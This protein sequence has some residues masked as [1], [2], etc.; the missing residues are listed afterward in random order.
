M[1]KRKPKKSSLLAYLAI[2]IGTIFIIAI[3]MMIGYTYGKNESKSVIES[4]QLNTKELVEKLRSIVSSADYSLYEI[5]GAKHEYDTTQTPPKPHL[6]EEPQEIKDAK[7]VIIID[8]VATAKDIEMIKSTKLPLVMSFLPPNVIHPDSALLASNID[9]YMVHLPLEAQNYDSPE[10]ITLLAGASYDEIDAQI[11]SVKSL[12][13]KVKYIN[14]H[15]GSKFTDDRESMS[16]LLQVL[17]AHNIKFVDSRTIGSSKVAEASKELGVRYLG[18]DIFLDHE[19]GVEYAKSQIIEAIKV[20]K[21][22]G[23]A[24]AIG[25][26]KR[27]TIRAL[28]ES[29]EL[30]ESSVKIVGIEQI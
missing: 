6:R 29:K 20:A 21:K 26:P 15:T 24:I 10:P 1:A 23:Y 11:A 3:S 17:N 25:H 13:P 2:F 9:N 4:E 30:L 22:H 5:E 16:K 18:R 14:N 27:D 7:L 8:D 28:I 19:S 12:F